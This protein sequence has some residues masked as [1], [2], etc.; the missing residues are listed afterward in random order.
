MLWSLLVVLSVSSIV[1][2][3]Q[4]VGFVVRL[5]RLDGHLIRER[6]VQTASLLILVIWVLERKHDSDSDTDHSL[7]EPNVSDG[8]VDEHGSWVA[9]GDDVALLV[10][11]DTGSLLS[12][13]TGDDDFATVGL[14]VSHDGVDG[15]HGAESDGKSF[16]ET[17]L[18]VLDLSGGGEASVLDWVDDDLQLALWESESLLEEHGDLVEFSVAD[19]S[20]VGSDDLWEDHG[21]HLGGL[22]GDTTVSIAGQSLAQ[23]LV[24]FSVKDSVRDELLLLVDLSIFEITH[25]ILY[26]L[27]SKC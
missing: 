4:D 11:H 17:G 18:E 6:D 26:F 8:L 20:V 19:S 23:E 1:V 5:W 2:L 21:L 25:L 7:L 27:Y 13:L 24:D 3:W 10:L 16:E 22:D 14:T 9:G 12:Q 15:P